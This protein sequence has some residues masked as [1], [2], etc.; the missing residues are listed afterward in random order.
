MTFCCQIQEL[1]YRFSMY[2]IFS[3]KDNKLCI[4]YF[5]YIGHCQTNKTMILFFTYE[6]QHL[7]NII[8][9]MLCVFLFLFSFSLMLFSPA[10]YLNYYHIHAFHLPHVLSAACTYVYSCCFNASVSEYVCKLCYV[11]FH[12]IKNPCKQAP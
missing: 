12:R 9:I 7:Y 6:R 10:H 5:L 3:L 4:I 8:V 2:L 11:F 1:F